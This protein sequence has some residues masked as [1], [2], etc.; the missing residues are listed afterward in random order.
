MKFRIEI[1]RDDSEVIHRATVDE[2]SPLRAR[3]RAASLLAL[4]S[5]RGANRARVLNDKDEE[6]YKL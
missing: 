6:L 1:T 5:G 2:M 4:H 3:V